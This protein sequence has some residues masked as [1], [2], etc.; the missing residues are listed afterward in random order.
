MAIIKYDHK[1]KLVYFSDS[2]DFSIPD[3]ILPNIKEK[4]SDYTIVTH[5]KGRQR[6]MYGCSALSTHDI[7]RFAANPEMNQN[8]K[9][10]TEENQDLFEIENGIYKLIYPP[11]ELMV[12]SQSMSTLQRQKLYLF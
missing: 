10:L 8:L 4:L 5:E 1:S 3:E 9:R 11:A 2:L 12:I 7:S 6:A